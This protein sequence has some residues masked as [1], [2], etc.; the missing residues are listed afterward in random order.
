MILLDLDLV[1]EVFP[2]H[3]P[4]SFPSGLGYYSDTSIRNACNYLNTE[5]VFGNVQFP[6]ENFSLY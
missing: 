6:N 2:L 5:V 4:P 3:L 1:H